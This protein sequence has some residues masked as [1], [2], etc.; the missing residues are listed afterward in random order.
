MDGIL[1]GLTSWGDVCGNANTPG[2]YTKISLFR[3]YIDNIVK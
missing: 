2:V 3:N 1:I